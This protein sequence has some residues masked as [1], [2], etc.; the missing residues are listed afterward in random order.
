MKLNDFSIQ[1][2]KYWIK[3]KVG[4]RKRFKKKKCKAGKI[5][6]PD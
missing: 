3:S 2:V 5:D 6:F 1:L 4:K